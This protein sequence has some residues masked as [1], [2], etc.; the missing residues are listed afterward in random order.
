MRERAK[1]IIIAVTNDIHYDQRMQRIAGSL[2]NHYTTTLVGRTKFKGQRPPSLSNVSTHLLPCRFTKGKWFYLEYQLRLMLYL[3]RSQFDAIYC[4]DLDTLWGGFPMAYLRRKKRIFDAH[5]YFTEVPEVIHRPFIRYAWM[6]TAR[7]WI[8]KS[9]LCFTVNQSLADIFVKKYEVLFT[10]IHNMP[11]FKEGNVPDKK[12]EKIILYQGVLNMG[13]GLEEIISTMPLLPDYQLWIAGE[14][15][16]SKT[17]RELAHTLNVSR[18]VHFLGYLKPIELDRI[19][20][21]CSIGINLLYGTSLNYY[22][23]LANKFFDYVQAGIPQITMDFPVYQKFN[24]QFQVALLIEDLQK[25]TLCA[26]IKAL[27]NEQLYHQLKDNCFKASK[28]WVWQSESQQLLLSVA[29]IWS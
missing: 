17:L 6:V 11:I 2:S 27:E 26:A 20:P 3:F 10:A 8:P 7:I 16:L 23:S 28:T 19:T 18:Q 22:Y 12:P 14:G 1:H 13:R 9:H 5:E 25:D 15:D 21:L 4:V 24:T 29:K